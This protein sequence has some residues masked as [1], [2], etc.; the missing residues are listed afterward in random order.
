M[1][2]DGVCTVCT[3]PADETNSALCNNC[4]GRFHLR[5]RR[6]A[7]GPECGRVWVNEQFLALEYACDVCLGAAAPPVREPPIARGH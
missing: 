4:D 7:D 6:D 2:H 1:P 3:A 5:L